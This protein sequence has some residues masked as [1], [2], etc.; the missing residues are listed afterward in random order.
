[1]AFSVDSN[2][3]MIRYLGTEKMNEI[4]EEMPKDLLEVVSNIVAT[5]DKEGRGPNGKIDMAKTVNIQYSPQ[6]QRTASRIRMI[7]GSSI[8]PTI[9]ASWLV[10]EILGLFE[11][12]S[13]AIKVIKKRLM[14][15][16]ER[17]L[18]EPLRK[19][20][21]IVDEALNK[22]RA[23]FKNMKKIRTKAVQ[24]EC[25][26]CT[27]ILAKQEKAF[28]EKNA[29]QIKLEELKKELEGIESENGILVGSIQSLQANCRG[30]EET[31][32]MF[33]QKTLE[34][35]E[36][37][38]RWEEIKNA[39]ASRDME[40]LMNEKVK[41]ESEAARQERMIQQNEEQIESNRQQLVKLEE[42]NQLGQTVTARLEQQYEEVANENTKT[43][44]EIDEIVAALEHQKNVEKNRKEQEARTMKEL[45]MKMLPS[46]KFSPFNTQPTPEYNKQYAESGNQK[47]NLPTKNSREVQ[48]KETIPKATYTCQNPSEPWSQ[49]RSVLDLHRSCNQERNQEVTVN[50]YS[51]T[52]VREYHHNVGNDLTNRNLPH[53]KMQNSQMNQS[54]SSTAPNLRISMENQSRALN[55]LSLELSAIQNTHMKK[56]ITANVY[57][58][59]QV[60][61]HQHHVDNY[62]RNRNLQRNT[63]QNLHMNQSTPSTG[64]NGQNSMENLQQSAI[65]IT[66]MK[67]SHTDT[68]HNQQNGKKYLL[69]VENALNNLNAKDCLLNVDNGAYNYNLQRIDMQVSQLKQLTSASA[70]NLRSSMENVPRVEKGAYNFNFQRSAIQNP[71]MKRPATATAYDKKDIMKYLENGLND[72]NLQNSIMNG[73]EGNQANTKTAYTQQNTNHYQPHMENGLSNFEIQSIQENASSSTAEYTRTMMPFFPLLSNL[74]DCPRCGKKVVKHDRDSLCAD[75]EFSG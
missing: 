26:N 4:V 43:K 54:T 59:P 73:K 32:R 31:K 51:S 1:M 8:D 74:Y 40:H 33:K 25:H 10:S 71:H 69:H 21:K 65:Q 50:V 58:P 22:M 37:Q 55:N 75:C 23:Q 34:A 44:A 12:F 29:S 45:Q 27:G 60:R 3:N 24:K 68:A 72:L 19:A 15:P 5:V 42:E 41:L 64:F 61:E 62:Y 18:M 56:S 9:A 39:R 66:H 7:I 13:D 17:D 28:F 47:F 52:Q 16:E 20:E 35:Q 2:V 63:M 36:A 48:I 49:L 46:T 67:Q 6:I 70:Y 38:R 14:F 53:S 11:N 57:S 30:L